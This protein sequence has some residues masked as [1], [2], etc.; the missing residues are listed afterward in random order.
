MN[1]IQ[2]TVARAREAFDRETI[3][4]A[5]VP[6][7]AAVLVTALFVIPNYMRALDMQDEAQRLVLH[8]EGAHVVGDHEERGDQCR[9][10]RGHHRPHH[11]LAVEHPAHGVNGRVELRVHRRTSPADATASAA[12]PGR[13]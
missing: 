1:R 3:A 4:W 11:G 6:G 9:G 10:D 7:T 8:V 2:A 13:T 5:I 12:R